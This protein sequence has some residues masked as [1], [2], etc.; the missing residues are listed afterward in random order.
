MASGDVGDTAGGLWTPFKALASVVED[1]I[2]KKSPGLRHDLER[3]LRAHKPHFTALLK[4]TSRSPSDAE[5]VRK[6]QNE[7]IAW[8]PGSTSGKIE[9]I[10]AQV[11]EEALILAELFDMNEI[12]SLQL[13]L[14]GEE[15]LNQYPGLTRGLVAV[16][17][18]YDGRKSLVQSLRTLIQGRSGVTWTLELPEEISELV[19][20]F[21]D[22]LV[23]G[24]LVEKILG[25]L[26][27]LDWNRE[28][29]MLQKNM[30][31]G[32]AKH[33]RQVHDLFHDINQSLADCILSFAAQSGLSQNDTTRLID[34]LSKVKIGDANVSGVIENTHLTLLMALLYAL[35]VS[36]LN[37]TD[38]GETTIRAL[39]ILQD[40]SFIPI[41]HRELGPNSNR[42]WA[43]PAI[44]SLAQFAWSMTVS[45]LRS[46]PNLSTSI[47]DDD[48]AI[49]DVAL[50]HRLFHHLPDVILSNPMVF[51]EEFYVRRL[52]QLITDF[53]VLMPLK[54]KELRNRADDAARNCL[55]HEQEGIHYN[56]PKAGQHFEHMMHT[57]A[58]LYEEDPLNLGL[59]LE[60]WC[61]PDGN[62]SGIAERYPQRQV[63]LYKFVRLAGDLLMPTLYTP[64]VKMLVGLSNHPQSALHCFNLLKLNGLTGQQGANSVSWDHFY[65]SMQQ[66]FANLRQEQ[67][68]SYSS[69]NQSST[70]VIYRM[71]R[72][73][74]RGISPAEID[75]LVAVLK[76]VGT[77]SHQCE[78]VRIAMAENTAWQPLL[79]LMGLLGCAVPSPLKAEILVTLGA[80]SKS[81]SISHLV[82]ESIETSQIITTI[83][84]V[85]PNRQ[86]LGTELEEV[87]TRNE[88]FP[89]TQGFLQLLDILAHNS[90]P[91]NLGAG[92]R[93]PGLEPYLRFIRDSIF[94][95]FSTRAYKIPDEKWKVASGCLK[96]FKVL[97]E[98]YDPSVSDFN[99]KFSGANQSNPERSF[100][101]RHAGF[102]LMIH[103][104]Q[105]SETLRTILFILNEGC[106]HL[107]MFVPFP[108]KSNLEE[109]CLLSLQILEIV[110]EKQGTFLAC[111]RESNTSMLLSP[112]DQL[113]LGVNP[114]SGK[115]D[116]MHNVAKF[117]TY[118]WWLPAQTYFAIKVLTYVSSSV[119]AQEGLI[120]T[121]NHNEDTAKTI[122]K[123]FTDVLDN[124][125]F[126][127]V[128]THD[129]DT[130]Q[131]NG[132]Y[133]A[134]S[135]IAIVELLL[136]GLALPV[137]ASLSHF[138]LG[139]D[140]KKGVSKTTLQPP[141]ING[142]IR[143][144]F[145]AVLT[146]LRPTSN[147]SISPNLVSC[148]H[149][150]EKAF[151]LIYQLASDFQTYEPILR[152]LR[153][154]EDF[155]SSQLSVLPLPEAVETVQV[156][157]G[158]AWLLKTLAI[159]LKLVCSSRL[160]SQVAL[161]I[162]LLLDASSPNARALGEDSTFLNPETTFSQLSRSV[163]STMMTS[164]PQASSRQHR[165]LEILNGINF[166]ELPVSVPNWELFD[167]NQIKDVIKSCEKPSFTG[168]KSI[169]VP[170]VHRILSE[171]LANLQG[172]TAISQRQIIQEDIKRI[173][174]YVVDL[175][176][177]QERETAKKNILD[178]WRQ[179]TEVML[180]SVPGDI[181][182]S[183]CKQ[184]LLL[185][186]LQTL[187][188]K[189][190][191]DD[192]LPE[193]ANQVSG[194]VLLLLASLR[195]T[196]TSSAETGDSQG[197]RVD[198][199]VSILDTTDLNRTSASV[200]TTSLVYS[201]SLYVILKGL[202]L[203]INSTSASAQ[204]VRSNL[205]GALLN[206]LRIGKADPSSSTMAESTS[207][208]KFRKA[209]LD[210]ILD[211]GENFLDIL[212]RDTVS[213]HNIRRMLAL[214]V[215]DELIKLD[216]RGRWTFYMSNQ[217][218]LRHIIESLIKEDEELLT[219]LSPS[220]GDLRLLYTY[221][222]KMAMLVRLASTVSG[223]ELLLESG[224]MVRLAEM[225]VFSARP[226][227]S[228]ALMEI[229]DS[230]FFPSPFS[231]YHQILFPALTLC[232]AL[233]ASLGS[234]NRSVTSQILH[235]IT[236]NDDL[237]RTILKSR[238]LWSLTH[239]RELSLLTGLIAQ[240][241]SQNELID[242]STADL[243]L[244]AFLTLVQRLML[245]LLP[246]FDLNEKLMDLLE[247][248]FSPG[249]SRDESV[250]L[251]LEINSHVMCFAKNL[252]SKSLSQSKYCRIMFAPSLSEANENPNSAEERARVNIP[253]RPPSLGQVVLIVKHLSLHLNETNRIVEELKTKLN[254]ISHLSMDELD[255]HV[256][257]EMALGGNK[258][259]STNERRSLA[260]SNI[261]TSMKEKEHEMG[262][263][264]G[265]I[266]NAILLIWAHVEHFIF[267][268]NVESDSTLTPYQRAYRLHI[269]DFHPPG[270]MDLELSSRSGLSKESVQKLKEETKICFNDALFS[271]LERVNDIVARANPDGT[272]FLDIMIR[273]LKRLATLHT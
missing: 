175:N 21:T 97:L 77:V 11:V 83:P 200:T 44:Q 158:I 157:K 257:S 117:I 73:M 201:T 119:T 196:Y 252:V 268:A 198:N 219:L 180:C 30:A 148:P 151:H 253:N 125:D 226:D 194:V 87:E 76:L 191:V 7:G 174:I 22:E 183:S 140:L 127:A 129:E 34:Y 241:V 130:L 246:Q 14:L 123:G 168:E 149:L 228:P 271:K 223:A 266:E 207:Y 249:K 2:L 70:D 154:S 66:Y 155:L 137:R 1:A 232:Q 42:K 50:D 103:L 169:D 8:P 54:V 213:G 202:I 165:L 238:G 111:A 236:A 99:S 118:S 62:S 203:W 106:A 45:T 234:D 41:I 25:L 214:S 269:D 13:L 177:S 71:A 264:K 88:E 107:D 233:L 225:N 239:L 108:G 100:L 159:E 166:V 61:P 48:E 135:R 204:K 153:S 53:I 10:P 94:L 64:Y 46:V 193:L 35:D 143:T 162:N 69:G 57:I 109:A 245:A 110:L 199:F 132:R 258:V 167:G 105:S 58:K 133:I 16:L 20:D 90:I 52:H 26:Q 56:V 210:I 243:G 112:A 192:T 181:L 29:G 259:L 86:C 231:R 164:R 187:L 28:N 93:V 244:P 122:V 96:F 131:E 49:M 208:Q 184:Q 216:G 75:G 141:G 32:H 186:V 12:S 92:A 152:Y 227:V 6:A 115:P 261:K 98:H 37:K 272:S 138:L 78:A 176:A 205:Y 38:D 67:I 211:F 221:E 63:S 146:I 43:N 128:E 173:L 178:A 163:P 147:K 156:I 139:F 170:K 160:R 24:G 17:L 189:V 218:Y 263:A 212:C 39:P 230:G 121:L 224:L 3:S 142:A 65:S 195:Q 229:D 265:T 80:F 150:C 185:D 220:P 18:Y 267:Y 113:L 182:S 251:V 188:N 206:Y 161:L 55:M 27:R 242:E 91:E 260:S 240:C 9:K 101:G 273:R 19:M 250:K 36:A 89:M 33:R 60:Y 82:W 68:P 51:K 209:N 31:L 247:K 79:V 40:K 222:S 255:A 134:A 171:E 254:T 74:T 136:N 72:P 197:G 84:S 262:L 145:H 126:N 104:L 248:H 5:L 4:N 59:A 114:R 256:S 23:E 15:Q 172:A 102:E 235:F 85:A 270:D 81:S 144:P 116:H 237:V 190:L 47:I 120:S 179:V 124:E 215:L 217:G 95:K